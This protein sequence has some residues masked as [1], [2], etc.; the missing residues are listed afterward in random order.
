M[1]KCCPR[2]GSPESPRLRCFTCIFNRV[3][4]HNCS[5]CCVF[6]VVVPRTQG[7][8]RRRDE[9]LLAKRQ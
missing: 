6:F 8:Y 1:T 9:N 2:V 3:E 7:Y 5:V 4:L